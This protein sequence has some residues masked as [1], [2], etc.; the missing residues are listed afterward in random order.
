M[1]LQIDLYEKIFVEAEGLESSRI[2]DYWF[3]I[4]ATP[5]KHSLLNTIKQ[6]SLMLK[7][8]L[9][10]HVTNR[11]DALRLRLILC[12]CLIGKLLE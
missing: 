8:H 10:D 6:W 3:R 7:Q 1:A 11:Y 4:D 12:I 9:I 5:F 2:L